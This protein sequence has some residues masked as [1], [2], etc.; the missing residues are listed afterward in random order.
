[1]TDW[2]AV[3]AAD[4]LYTAQD[5]IDPDIVYYESQGGNITPSQPRDGRR[6]STS[7]RAP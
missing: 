7:A 5:P 4:G 6:R 3:N 2:F 1:M